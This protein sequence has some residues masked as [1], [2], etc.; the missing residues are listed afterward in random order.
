MSCAANS[1]ENNTEK[2]TDNDSKQSINNHCT[3]AGSS[4]HAILKS[5]LKHVC[6][7]KQVL[8]FC[9]D[10]LQARTREALLDNLAYA[11]VSMGLHGKII[12]PLNTS[13]QRFGS[14]FSQSLRIELEAL[15]HDLFKR[16]VAHDRAFAYGVLVK[17]NNIAVIIDTCH[18]DQDKID[19]LIECNQ[20]LVECFDTIYSHLLAHE[21]SKQDTVASRQQLHK[22]QCQDIDYI[23][24]LVSMGLLN[25]EQAVSACGEELER[26]AAEILPHLELDQRDSNNVQHS[27]KPLFKQLLCHL[28]TQQQIV[29]TLMQYLDNNADTATVN[30]ASA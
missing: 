28:Q 14:G 7:L 21:H 5:A 9:S 29:Q 20:S 8:K 12:D 1:T 11:L 25:I 18:F 27:L 22:Q 15:D 2:H 19:L 16:D 3:G 17:T 10:S 6:F 24:D 23:R 13:E 26:Y 4:E 30:V